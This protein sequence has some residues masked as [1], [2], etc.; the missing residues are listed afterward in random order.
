MYTTSWH[1]DGMDEENIAIPYEWLNGQ[2]VPL[3]NYWT[4]YYPSAQ[5]RS[6]I[7]EKIFFK[8]YISSIWREIE[9]YQL[10]II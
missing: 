9:L 4:P 2:L 8:P 10:N 7:N 5:L 6:N 1:L 3:G